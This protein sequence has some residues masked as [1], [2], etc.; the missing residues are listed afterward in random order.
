MVATRAIVAT[1]KPSQPDRPGKGFGV[2]GSHFNTLNTTLMDLITFAYGVQQKQVI[3][4]PDWV[5]S[6][7]WDIEAQPD[8]PGAPSRGQ[9]RTMVQKL[10]ADRF[11]L[12]FHKDKQELAAY[13]LTMEKEKPM[14][15]KSDSGDALPGL[16][17][18]NFSPVTLT[19]RNALMDDFTQLLQS[20]VLDRPV[21]DQTG[22]DGRWNFLL[23]WTGDE[24]QFGGMGVKI[25]PPSDTA[26][27]PPQ[28]FTA[29]KEQL[30]LKLEAGKAQVEVLELDK[31]EKPSAN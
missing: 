12:K 14:M 18:T 19:V 20:A 30:G 8:V 3:G 17:F 23:K 16:F 2:R 31:V 13:L 15:A 6:D 11:Q 28:L 5:S 26:D 21:V 7:K 27:A 9:L 22:L 24:S 25:P 10:L 4:A 29:I 1:I